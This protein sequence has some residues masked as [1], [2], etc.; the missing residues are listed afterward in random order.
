VFVLGF[1]K[2]IFRQH[3]LQALLQFGLARQTRQQTVEHIPHH[4]RQLGVVMAGGG[5]F[6][7]FGAAQSWQ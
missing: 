5:E 7:Q 1:V 4:S 3:G 2:T 6:V